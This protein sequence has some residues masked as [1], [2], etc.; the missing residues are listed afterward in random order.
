MNIKFSI[1]RAECHWIIRRGGFAELLKIIFGRF[2][3][4][5]RRNT[6]MRPIEKLAKAEEFVHIHGD[7]NWFR[8]HYCAV[9]EYNPVSYAVDVALKAQDLFE[10]FEKE[11]QQ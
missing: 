3:F 2:E 10:Q 4:S 9:R 11:Y 5:K 8:E 1:G 7:S 6:K